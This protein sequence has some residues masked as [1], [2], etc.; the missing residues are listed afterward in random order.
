MINLHAVFEVSM[1]IDYEDL[2]GNAEC[3]NSGVLGARG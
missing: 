1:F 2:K 3:R